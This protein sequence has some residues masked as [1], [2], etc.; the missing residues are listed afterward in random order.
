MYSDA[1]IDPAAAN[2]LKLFAHIGVTY[3]P[4]QVA[5]RELVLNEG[6]VAI[7]ERINTA[8]VDCESKVEDKD[9]RENLHILFDLLLT[10]EDRSRFAGIEA[11][12]SSITDSHKLL[13]R[14]EGGLVD[15]RASSLKV[16][17]DAEVAKS[18]NA[19]AKAKKSQRDIEK[20][21]K[22]AL[23]ASAPEPASIDI[24]EG[25]ENLNL[26]AEPLG[27]SHEDA[28]KRLW[29]RLAEFG[30]ACKPRKE[31][32]S[33]IDL[34]AVRPNGHSTHNLFL[35]SKKPKK[36]FLVSTRQSIH[37]N[38]KELEKKLKVKGL[39]MASTRKDEFCSTC[40]C[41]TPLSLFNNSQGSVTP[42]FDKG[43][44]GLSTLRVCAGCTNPT[45]HSQHNIV[46]ITPK[47]LLQLL[48]ESNTPKCI[49]IE[50]E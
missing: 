48:K 37:L 20:E 25:I 46:D 2:Q 15:K 11:W 19:G 41:I 35:K 12:S 18:L 27:M 42:V 14:R 29:E 43:L 38:M 10:P 47:Q 34:E 50:C 9:A 49:E 33:D 13:V 5:K 23:S 7:L 22:A 3:H 6:G 44:F 31:N 40:G 17:A 24:T 32:E 26:S 28:Q 30:E 21:K 1:G 16:R 39:R 45:D 4:F 36:M 8:I